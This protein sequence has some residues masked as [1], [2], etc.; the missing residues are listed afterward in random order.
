MEVV[1]LFVDLDEC[2]MNE[3]LCSADADCLNMDGGYECRCKG[4]FVGDGF[5]CAGKTYTRV[6]N[7]SYSLTSFVH[8]T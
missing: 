2:Y 6:Y 5:S 1:L 7:L 4:E 8:S 3:H